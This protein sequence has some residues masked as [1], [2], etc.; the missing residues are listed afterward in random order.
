MTGTLLDPSPA[1]RASFDRFALRLTWVLVIGVLGVSMTA[2]WLGIEAGPALR[3][4]P[5][6]L[7]IV[8]FGLPHGAVD[9]LIPVRLA[10]TPLRRSLG[11]VGLGYLVLGGLYLILW[12]VAPLT[13]AMSFLAVTWFHW[14]QGDVHALLAFVEAPHLDSRP[15][16]VGTLLVRGGLPMLVPLIGFPGRY[17]TVLGE[18]LALFVGE[19]G[20]GN[21]TDSSGEEREGR[22]G[23]MCEQQARA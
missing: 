14:G 15:R 12:L 13:A 4:G 5:L 19:V 17:Q 7:S 2:R 3:Y 10:E 9:H 11:L 1:L 23:R 18:W 22:R 6:L 21:H 16:R 8:L 20:R